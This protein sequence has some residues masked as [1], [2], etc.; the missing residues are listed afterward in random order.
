[1][2]FA[3][4]Y[5][6]GRLALIGSCVLAISLTIYEFERIALRPLKIP[7]S[8]RCVF[9]LCCAGSFWALTFEENYAMTYLGCLNCLLFSIGIWVSREKMSNEALLQSLA[10]GSAGMLYCVVLP[11]FAARTLFL[12]HGIQWF[13]ALLIIVFCGDTAAY[14]GGAFLGHTKLRPSLSPKKTIEGAIAGT[15]G[16]VVSGMTFGYFLLPHIPLLVLFLLTI[17]MSFVAQ[18]GDLFAS[19]VKRVGHVKDSGHI[20]PGHGGVLDRFDGVFFAAPILFAVAAVFEKI[21]T[22]LLGMLN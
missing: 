22:P 20:M 7:P 2:L 19:L 10:L 12:S 6:G 15:I 17:V 14:F 13:Y 11:S 21:Q 4:T 16:S 9:L 18:S 5:Y 1:M 3:L 8:L